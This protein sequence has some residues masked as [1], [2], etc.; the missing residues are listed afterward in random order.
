[1]DKSQQLDKGLERNQEV[2]VKESTDI[3]NV[4]SHELDDKKEMNKSKDRSFNKDFPNAV[5]ELDSIIHE[6]DSSFFER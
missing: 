6:K 5:Y 1:M 3:D 4:H 2:A